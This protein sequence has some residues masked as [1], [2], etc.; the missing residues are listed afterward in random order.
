[1][2]DASA[3]SQSIPKQMNAMLLRHDGYSNSQ[4]GPSIETLEPYLEY[5][6]TDVPQPGEKQVLIR[7]ILGNINPSDLHFIKGEYGQPRRA[8]VAG[9]FEGVGEVVAAGRGG[10]AL[11]GKR[12]AF[13]VVASGSGAWAQYALTDVTSCI[14]L[15]SDLRDE[16]AATLFINPL[17]AIAMFDEVKKSNSKT[18][19]MTAAASQ[20]CKLMAGLAKDEGYEPISIVRRDEHIDALKA[21]GSTHVLNVNDEKFASQATALLRQEKPRVL[22]DAVGDQIS[23]KLFEAMPNRARWLIYGKLSKETP[24]LDQIGQ[25]IFMDKI[26]EG[27][28]LV[29][30]IRNTPAKEQMLAIARVQELFATGKWK[31][32]ISAIVP[33]ATAFEDLPNALSGMNKGKVM[34]KP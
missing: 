18:F 11:I 16:D 30:W 26:I 33:L 19:I 25:M 24:R 32:D 3:T 29:K 21:Y 22:L 2:N 13:Y 4:E 14:P 31:T 12:V 9:G 5:R 6:K 7:V 8:G 28:W 20:L 15:R 27:F 34:I 23:A 10:E 17:T 1:M